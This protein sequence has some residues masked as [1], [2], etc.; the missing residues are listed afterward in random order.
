MVLTSQQTKTLS[1]RQGADGLAL[2]LIQGN[3]L[4]GD[5]REIDVR[6]ADTAYLAVVHRAEIDDAVLHVRSRSPLGG[7]GNVGGNLPR[8]ELDAYWYVEIVQYLEFSA[9]ACRGAV[10]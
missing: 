2:H 4:V 8:L 9:V 1:D 10:A 5:F 6:E 3:G 7:T